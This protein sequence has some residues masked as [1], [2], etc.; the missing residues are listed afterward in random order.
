[1]T[2]LGDDDDDELNGVSTSVDRIVTTVETVLNSNS[3]NEDSKT[4]KRRS[5]GAIASDDG[6]V[7]ISSETSGIHI[8]KL[9]LH[10]WQTILL[11]RIPLEKFVRDSELERNL[12]LKT[13]LELLLKDEEIDDADMS[14]VMLL[15]ALSQVNIVVEMIL[16]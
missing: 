14:R 8:K 15:D 13:S 16:N 5:K 10:F 3:T 6:S 4:P 11:R 9:L 1:M 2:S 12:I 7:Q